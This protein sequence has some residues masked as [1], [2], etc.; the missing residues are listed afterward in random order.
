MHETIIERNACVIYYILMC[1]LKFQKIGD[2]YIL[3]WEADW[4]QE[5]Y[6]LTDLAIEVLLSCQMVQQAY[7]PQ[8][9]ILME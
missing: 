3:S 6:Y 5:G 1:I 9:Q 4:H 8:K 7:H 2:K